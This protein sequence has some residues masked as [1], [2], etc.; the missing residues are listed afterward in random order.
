ISTP[1]RILQQTINIAGSL[2]VSA[3]L[4]PFNVDPNGT[5]DWT[6][7]VLNGTSFLAQHY[8]DVIYGGLGQT[9]IPRGPGSDSHPGR[10]ALPIFWNKP[11]V[12]PHDYTTP[13]SGGGILGSDPNTLLFSAYDE[14]NPR[15][16]V[17]GTA[18]GFFL[19]FNQYEGIAM[20]GTIAG[21]APGSIAYAYAG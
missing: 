18:N 6:N 9:L 16:I 7:S 21:T 10:R 12:N 8:D 5:T 19:N 14:A 17:G 15:T 4:T 3:D 2:T 1:G 13:G 20:A 11:I